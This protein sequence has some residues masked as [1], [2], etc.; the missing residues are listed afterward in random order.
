MNSD[1]AQWLD[2]ILRWVHVFAGIMWVG[3]TYFFTWL[4]GRFTE[5]ENSATEKGEPVWMVHSGGF[6]RVEKQKVPQLMPQTLHWFRWE[7]AITWLSGFCLFVVV[8]YM[9]GLMI[10]AEDSRISNNEAIG[11]SLG[12]LVVGWVIYDVVLGRIFKNEKLLPVVAFILIV[13]LSSF[14]TRYFAGRA[15]YL[16]LGA[17]FGTIMVANVWMR[18]L[19]A[20]RRMV[21]ALKAGQ[22]PNLEEAKR[23]KNAS[24]H[25]TFMAVPIVFIMLSYHF[26]TAVTRGYNWKVLPLVVLVGWFAAKLIRRA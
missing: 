4:D 2:A 10:S 22:T 6:Y 23:A 1:L 13:A 19:P 7:A 18:I 15:A 5:L 16:Q 14:L 21:A 12:L 20:Q 25:N 26:P 17:M 9:G 11:L 8:Y 24:R 3:T